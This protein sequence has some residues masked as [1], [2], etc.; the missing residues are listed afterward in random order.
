MKGRTVVVGPEI[1]SVRSARVQAARRL[2]KRAFRAR[3]GRFLAEGPQAVREAV[4]RPDTVL[5]LFVTA[6]GGRPSR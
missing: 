3:E 5:E 6:R 4:D 1:T 2:A